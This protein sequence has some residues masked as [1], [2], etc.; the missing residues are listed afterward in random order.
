MRES[1][2]LLDCKTDQYDDSRLLIGYSFP[3]DWRHTPTCSSDSSPRTPTPHTHTHIHTGQSPMTHPSISLARLPDWTQIFLERASPARKCDVIK[4][5]ERRHHSLSWSKPKNSG[6]VGFFSKN[7][8]QIKK[9][10][11]WAKVYF[12]NNRPGSKLEATLLSSKNVLNIR[13]ILENRYI[14][15]YD[16]VRPNVN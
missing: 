5:Q 16:E 4:T 10:M 11:R 7:R 8:F 14:F 3:N 12:T 2:D 15:G 1:T 9:N 6:T 13:F